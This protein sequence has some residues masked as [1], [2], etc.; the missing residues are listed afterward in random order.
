MQK[1]NEG[2]SNAVIRFIF[3]V[4]IKYCEPWGGGKGLSKELGE[5]ISMTTAY[6]SKTTVEQ[7]ESRGAR[8]DQAG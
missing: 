1:G 6:K 2:T 7:L 8:R 5:K 3:L 4:C